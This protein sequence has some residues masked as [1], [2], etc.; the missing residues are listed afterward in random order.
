[1]MKKFFLFLL[2][3]QI[4]GCSSTEYGKS[5]WYAFDAKRNAQDATQNMEKKFHGS[6]KTQN[7]LL[8]KRTID[9][10]LLEDSKCITTG[11]SNAHN[12]LSNAQLAI[13]SR[14]SQKHSNE[15]VQIGRASWYGGRWHGRKTASGVAFNKNS[16]TAAHKS[17]PLMSA[18]KVTNLH[19]N[20]EVV[21]LINDRGP[22]HGDLLLDVSQKAAT[23]LGMIKPGTAMVKIEPFAIDGILDLKKIRSMPK[24][25]R[26]QIIAQK[27]E[28]INFSLAG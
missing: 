10:E 12:D 3:M 26:N 21:L 11:H 16:Y 27:I 19:N 6:V 13:C 15:R 9:E 7:K 14:V 18:V 23:K 17:L 5:T 4:I 24:W 8:L 25:K 1:M 28:H 22:Y 20:K 2:S